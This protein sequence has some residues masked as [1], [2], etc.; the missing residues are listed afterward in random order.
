MQNVFGCAP[1]SIRYAAYLAEVPP[2]FPFPAAGSYLYDDKL[3]PRLQ[4]FC[5]GS[6]IFPPDV[7]PVPQHFQAVLV[8]LTCL[9]RSVVSPTMTSHADHPRSQPS[10]KPR[11]PVPMR[12]SSA[13]M[14]VIDRVTVRFRPPSV[15]YVCF[16]SARSL[17]LFV[18]VQ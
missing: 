11:S 6:E 10:L 13:T 18:N 2:P 9:V 4:L 3:P 1:I 7:D 17:H 8:I 14:P 16:P 15:A 5:P 12:T